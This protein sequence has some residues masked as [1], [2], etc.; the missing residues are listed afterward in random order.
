MGQTFVILLI[1]VYDICLSTQVRYAWGLIPRRRQLVMIKNLIKSRKSGLVG[2]S[3]AE[4]SA[5]EEYAGP[6]TQ[7]NEQERELSYAN[8]HVC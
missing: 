7:P 1:V 3:A 5:Q 6:I 2:C 4:T 8:R